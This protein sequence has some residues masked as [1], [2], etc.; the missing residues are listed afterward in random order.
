[1][2][3]TVKVETESMLKVSAED[4]ASSFATTPEEIEQYCGDLI[5]T[6]NFGYRA[7]EAKERDEVILYVL[8]KIE[9][10]TQIVGGPGREQAWEK[11][12]AENLQDFTNSGFD[13]DK[14]VPKFIRPDQIIRFNQDYIKPVNPTFELDYY[15]VFRQWL[16]KKYFC[17]V[18]SIYEFG[19]GTGFNLVELAGMYPDK[20]LYGLDFVPSSVEL[21]NRIGQNH[22]LNIT[23]HLCD[24]RK[25]DEAFEISENSAI[26]TIGA[27]EQLAGDFEPILHYFTKQSPKFCIHIEPT[28]ELYDEENLID[29]LGAKFH[30][31]RGYT[32]G[33]LPCLKQL[34]EKGE[35]EIVKVKRLYFG[36]LFME[37]YTLIVWRPIKT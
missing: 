7:L 27:L 8:K 18:E 6:K 37:G 35:I 4:F 26:L 29:Y 22:N 17:T 31:K 15:S 30:R 23:G 11:G 24:M 13:L 2:N 33:Y 16:F 1:M 3:S 28:I 21:V 25:P 5:G 12:W 32:Q 14:L 20:R 34:E 9:S 19:C 10:D 36:S